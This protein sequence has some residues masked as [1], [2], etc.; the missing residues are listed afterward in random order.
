MKQQTKFALAAA[1]LALAAELTADETPAAAPQPTGDGIPTPPQP[2][3]PKRGRPPAKPEGAAAP[4]QESVPAPAEAA[5][6]A[7]A[8][9]P[10]PEPAASPTPE[11]APA[12]AEPAP[13]ASGKTVDD[14]REIIEPLVKGGKK[15]A[16]KEIVGRFAPTLAQ[17]N[18]SDYPAFENAINTE[19]LGKPAAA[20]AT[21]QEEEI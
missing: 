14:L 13:V 10:T 7:A 20:T 9:T 19:L 15:D 12:P 6:P 18:P 1:L 4:T 21:P 2:D 11:P 3:K 17:M 5:A 8:P 16:V